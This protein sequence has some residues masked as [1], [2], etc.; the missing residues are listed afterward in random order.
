MQDED[1]SVLDRQASERPIECVAV[2]DREECIRG[3]RPVDR[4]DA[5]VCRPRAPTPGLGVARVDEQA[6]DPGFEAIWVSQRRELAPDGDESAL[7]GVL[8]E[9]VV[10]QDPRGK[11]V[12][13]VAGHV[14]QRR[15]RIAITVLCLDDE[16]SHH[17]SLC[18][19]CRMAPSH[20]MSTLAGRNV[21]ASG[22]IDSGG[23]GRLGS[24][25]GRRAI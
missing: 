23:A 21:Q 10:A 16:V 24:G 15:E 3:R 12:H 4:Q 20:P 6:P 25:R 11:R 19:R 18:R 1:R 17:R 14:D 9:I 7:Q 8:G 13:P 2:V 22:Q 5:D